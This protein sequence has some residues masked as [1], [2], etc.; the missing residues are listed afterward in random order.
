MYNPQKYC[1][2]HYYFHQ[3]TLYRLYLN[4]TLYKVAQ[5]IRCQTSNQSV[6]GSI[7]GRALWSVLGHDSLFH[8]A[9]VHPAEKW[10]PSIT[11]AVLR[12]CVLYAASCSGIYLGGLKWFTC[13]Q[14]LLGEEG[15]VN[16]SMDTRL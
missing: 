10:V 12:D 2:D 7:R 1:F 3:K 15:H 8:I 13:V 16:I 4:G 9:S 14:C 5:L 6:A 11:K